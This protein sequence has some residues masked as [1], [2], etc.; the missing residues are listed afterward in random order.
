[1]TDKTELKPWHD[2]AE[3]VCTEKCAQSG[4]KPCS[5][6]SDFD[7]YCDECEGIAKA[8]NDKTLFERMRDVQ[9]PDNQGLAGELIDMSTTCRQAAIH[10]RAKGQLLLPEQLELAATALSNQDKLVENDPIFNA[11]AQEIVKAT[12]KFPQWPDRLIDAG[13]IVAEEAGEL[14]KA[15]LQRTYEKDK[16]SWDDVRMEAIQTAAMCYRFLAS[17]HLVNDDAGSQ[18]NQPVPETIKASLAKGGE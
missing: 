16:C 1:M 15:C 14:S 13:N 5:K 11:I 18:H 4:D 3:I 10:L 6:I 12:E 9:A 2:T 17:L 8:V 7:G